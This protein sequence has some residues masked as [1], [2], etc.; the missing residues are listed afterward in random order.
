MRYRRQSIESNVVLYLYIGIYLFKTTGTKPLL[1]KSQER[2]S[3]DTAF[4]PAGCP[5]PK[6]RHVAAKQTAIIII[7]RLGSLVSVY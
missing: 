1:G 2:C 5:P 7:I 3:V 6:N 4:I